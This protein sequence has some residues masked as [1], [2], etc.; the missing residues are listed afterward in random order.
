M[1]FQY[2]KYVWGVA[3][4]ALLSGAF[5]MIPGAWKV[6]KKVAVSSQFP[7]GHY[8]SRGLRLFAER[9]EMYSGGELAL[10]VYD[11]GTLYKDSE[12][13]RAVRSGSVE[14]GLAPL[15]KWSGTV[16][17]VDVLELPFAFPSRP[18][19][20]AFLASGA[21]GMLDE[22]FAGYGVTTL[23]W[24]RP[25]FAALFTDKRPIRLPED[26]TGL[27][28]R[29][30][31]SV[32]SAVLKALGAKPLIVDSP[33]L[34]VALQRMPFDGCSAT[35]TEAHAFGLGGVERHALLTRHGAVAF[36]LQAE[37]SW[38]EGLSPL[39][40]TALQ[41]AASDAEAFMAK[42]AEQAE[43][44]A[45]QGLASAGV[46]VLSLNAEGRAAF[47]KATSGIGGAFAFKGDPLG[48][49]LLR[50]AGKDAP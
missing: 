21:R 20:D 39:Q 10:T 3:L 17:A 37:T 34:S 2:K 48:A 25:E 12:V 28:M 15:N 45:L 35:L 33:D 18:A 36:A 7:P 14:L 42:E 22:A 27:A 31:S 41:R 9:A 1:R 13:L 40:K 16:P 19:L 30:F 4:A 49:T 11:S 29:V 26:C 50:L 38:W 32:D 5:L 46:T 24:T 8:L 43:A 47:I 6:E 23:L 44:E